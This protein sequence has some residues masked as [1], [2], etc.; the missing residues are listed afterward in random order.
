MRHHRI[1]LKVSFPGKREAS[2]KSSWL[3]A[4]HG[5]L[6]SELGGWAAARHSYVPKVPKGTLHGRESMEGH[7]GT[8]LSLA[9]EQMPLAGLCL[10]ALLPPILRFP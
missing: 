10:L 8:E 7:G 3:L 4:A 6:Q 1:D 2:R 9:A 5:V